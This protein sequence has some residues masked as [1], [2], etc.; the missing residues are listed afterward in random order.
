MSQE[1][2]QSSGRQELSTACRLLH[3]NEKR[4]QE[5]CKLEMQIMRI[6]KWIV[7][8]NAQDAYDD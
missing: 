1:N 7:E 8:E 4:M 6:Q 3:E 2:A 5:R